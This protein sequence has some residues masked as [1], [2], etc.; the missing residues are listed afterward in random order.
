MPKS[1][2]IILGFPLPGKI[3]QALKF[4]HNPLRINIFVQFLFAFTNQVN[5]SAGGDKRQSWSLHCLIPLHALAT[6]GP[7]PRLE[8]PIVVACSTHS[9]VC[10][11]GRSTG[12]KVFPV[13][14]VGKE[15]AAVQNPGCNVGARIGSV[16]VDF[17]I[18]A[19]GDSDR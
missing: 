15:L 4:S 10:T 11:S 5:L 1:K 2:G 17:E 7:S 16:T 6:T 19:V 18:S 12:G 9:W 14:F 8:L 13:V 3:L